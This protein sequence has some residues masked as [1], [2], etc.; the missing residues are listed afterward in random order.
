[1]LLY[2]GGQN[3]EILGLDIFLF[4]ETRIGTFTCIMPVP[5]LHPPTHTHAR[6]LALA[7]HTVDVVLCIWV[8]IATEYI[9]VLPVTHNVHGQILIQLYSYYDV[10]SDV[11][12]ASAL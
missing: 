12:W 9:C 6:A 5:H 3:C 11:S 2:S 8:D 4:L 10:V 1:M 7:Q